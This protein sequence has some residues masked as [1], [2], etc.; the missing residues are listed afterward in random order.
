MTLL[1]ARAD[2]EHT[3]SIVALVN[4]AYS[5]EA[6]ATG[7]VGNRNFQLEDRTN[8]E[9]VSRIIAS[10]SQLILTGYR[11]GMLAACCSLTHQRDSTTLG[12]FAVDPA[13]QGTGAGRELMSAAESFVQEEWGAKRIEIQVMEHHLPL[14]EWYGRLG[15]KPNGERL[16]YKGETENPSA[17]LLTMWKHL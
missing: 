14:R 3:G 1:I 5:P 15:Y 10:E 9:Q 16:P 11:E 13:A 6:A 7:W 4:Q 12:L 2:P 17:W 8:T